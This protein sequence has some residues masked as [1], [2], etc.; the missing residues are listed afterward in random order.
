[1]YHYGIGKAVLPKG[2][3]DFC[4]SRFFY[5]SGSILGRD[6]C[7]GHNKQFASSYAAALSRFESLG[8]GYQLPQ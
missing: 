5:D 3:M 1:M 6:A 8:L 7:S 4:G 2:A